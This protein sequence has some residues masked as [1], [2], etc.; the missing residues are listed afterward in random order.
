M[1]R[2]RDAKGWDCARFARV[3]DEPKPRPHPAVPAILW[4]GHT[5]R[6]WTNP[7]RPIRGRR[8]RS[9]E[10]RHFIQR[11]RE[12]IDASACRRTGV[13]RQSQIEW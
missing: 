1:V 13:W 10:P 9:A 4:V 6:T 7:R 12:Q 11:Q 5:A 2:F 8:T 3:S